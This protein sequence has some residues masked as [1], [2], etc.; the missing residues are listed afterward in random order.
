MTNIKEI[1]STLQN[2]KEKLKIKYGVSE[3]GIF[4]SYV[5]NKQDKTSDIDI[6][7]EFEKPIDLLTYV[8]LKNYLSELLNTNV[9]LVMK[10]A[11]KSRIG[12]R[13]LKE[14]NIL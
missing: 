7:V 4:G 3:I 1:I 9:D 10:K 11:L 13:I 8:N 6:L 2:I 12:E 5:K 14:V